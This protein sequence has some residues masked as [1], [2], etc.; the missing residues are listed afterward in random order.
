MVFCEKK[1][2]KFI[3]SHLGI[4]RLFAIWGILEAIVYLIVKDDRVQ[5]VMIYSLIF[6]VLTL[7]GLTTPEVIDLI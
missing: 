6:L 4:I 5:S 2:E 7:Y 3:Y 1:Q